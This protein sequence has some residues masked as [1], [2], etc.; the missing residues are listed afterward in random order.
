MGDASLEKPTSHPAS[1]SARPESSKLAPDGSVNTQ[2]DTSRTAINETSKTERAVRAKMRSLK[3]EL[4]RAQDE[5]LQLKNE[6]SSL[7]A[8]IAVWSS[9]DN[10]ENTAMARRLEPDERYVRPD[11]RFS[12]E[13]WGLDHVAVNWSE[14]YGTESKLANA[15][16]SIKENPNKDRENEWARF[17][18]LED[19]IPTV[20]QSPNIPEGLELFIEG[21]LNNEL[22]EKVFE[23]PFLFLDELVEEDSDETKAQTSGNM[24]TVLERMIG[25]LKKGKLMFST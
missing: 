16:Q 11:T 15:V 3:A 17:A 20:L 8:E 24:G 4:K 9:H 18:K 2:P 7:K 10:Q 23:H 22:R 12:S 14:K 13:F 5:I 19:G 6:N 25:W 1:R 21:W